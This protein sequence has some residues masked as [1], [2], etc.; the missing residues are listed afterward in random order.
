[1]KLT[2]PKKFQFLHF[3]RYPKEVS[4][5]ANLLLERTYAILLPNFC[6]L[7]INP[8][9]KASSSTCRSLLHYGLF[10]GLLSLL[11][12]KWFEIRVFSMFFCLPIASRRF[13]FNICLVPFDHMMLNNLFSL[14]QTFSALAP[15]KVQPSRVMNLTS[16][17]SP[18]VIHRFILFQC[19]IYYTHG[20][21]EQVMHRWVLV[22][23]CGCIEYW[24][25]LVV[26]W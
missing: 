23:I 12:C 3:L 4:L 5:Y 21:C 17:F 19:T 15:W 24:V 18:F 11:G 8:R 20:P 6:T 10:L 25:Q 13:P 9:L 7:A 1:M 16:S 22:A 26:C 14:L 2:F